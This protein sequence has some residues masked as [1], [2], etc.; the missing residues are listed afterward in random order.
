MR[1]PAYLAAVVLSGSVA[2]SPGSDTGSDST[3][4]FT[5]RY[6]HRSYIVF[7]PPSVEAIA[8]YVDEHV[9]PGGMADAPYLA[10]ALPMVADCFAIDRAVFAGLVR[11]ESAYNR[12]L[13]SAGGAVGWTQFT[14]PGL[15]EVADQLGARGAD[16]ART[17]S[18]RYFK[19]RIDQCVTR[20]AGWVDAWE[21]AAVSGRTVK[22]ELSDL[23][24]NQLVY[25][26]IL[27]K[28]NLSDHY[29]TNSRASPGD[30]YVEA[31][32]RYNGD[33]P[34]IRAAYAEKI[35]Q[36]AAEIADG[37]LR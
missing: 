13:V 23:P 12:Y 6:V 8:S 28:T 20:G 11:Q 9:Q 26:A 22:Q 37:G 27:L 34:G 30:L 32:R 5:T 7:Q 18:T 3:G 10:E 21:I 29:T 25:G 33:T 36:F 17:D 24:L 4:L 35:L 16:Y 14:R 31:L 1:Y 19:A 2:C 15:A